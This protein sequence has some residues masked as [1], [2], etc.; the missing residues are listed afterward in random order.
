[1]HSKFTTLLLSLAL[2]LLVGCTPTKQSVRADADHDDILTAD[3]ILR[4]PPQT[5]IDQ[6][7]EGIA[8][9]PEA[10][11]DRAPPK[12]EIELGT[13]KFYKNQPLP[14]ASGGEGQVTFNFENQPIQAVVKAILGDM[15]QENYTIAPNVGGNVTY[16]TSRPIRREDAMP[17]LEMLLSWTGNALVHEGNRY[18]VLPSRD[19]IPGKLTPHAGASDAP[20]YGLRIYPLHYIS[21]VEMAKLLKPYVKPEAIVQIDPNRS[22]LVLAGN[23]S[24]LDIYQRTIDTF[25]VD[26]LKGM[27]IGVYNMQHV[28]VTKL[29]PD[30]DSLFGSKGESPLAGMFRFMPI[31]ETNSII[32]ITPQPEYLKQAEEWLYRLD[33]GSAENAVQ[34]Y[35]YNVK[36]LKAP[37]LADYLSQ[38]FL[39]TASGTHRS[40]TSG[41]VGPGLRSTSLNSMGGMG[42]GM[43]GFNSGMNYGSSLRPQSNI[44]KA[45]PVSSP[46]PAGGAAAAGSGKKETDI[47]ISAIEENNQLMIMAQPFEWE[48]MQA[49]IRRL[50]T[51]PL[52]VQ[53]EARILEVSLTDGLKFGV[54]WWL[55]N[56][57]TAPG[58]YDTTRNPWQYPNRYHRRGSTVGAAGPG[59]NAA[60]FFYSFLNSKFQVAISAL[61]SSGVAKTLSAP[62]LVVNNN[63][64]ASLQI[65]DQIP[66]QQTYYNG[67]GSIGNINNNGNNSGT[68]NPYGSGVMGSVQYLSTG[69][70]LSVLPR[71]NPGGLVYLDIDQQVSTPGAAASAGG[72]PPIAQRQFQ[73]SVAVQSGQTLLLGG[74]IK[75]VRQDADSSVPGIS[76]V[77]ILRRLFGSTSKSTNRTEL[78][79]LITP[80][81]I[82]NSDEARQVTEDYIKQFESLKPLRPRAQSTSA[83]TAEMPPS[84]GSA[85][86]QPQHESTEPVQESKREH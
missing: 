36:N 32:A 5:T 16:S 75:E 66:I 84:S 38:I 59:A 29:M 28:D 58:V 49:A 85:A 76:K 57:M 22:L 79:V 14:K 12:P 34:L 55:G 37:D 44:E 73:T 33:R 40:T 3:S 71:V 9:S 7:V 70:S 65:G 25:D 74:L 31:E 18:T 24:E 80:R 50:D 41:R 82:N 81:V 1:M 13:A 45:A 21:P 46:A 69:V 11:A 26:W 35:V 48:Q 64:E 83:P 62:S 68:Q 77:P 56:L 10:K 51:P 67:L 6:P 39:G 61:E 20:G 8:I 86:M 23:P 78:I 2:A 15:L 53:I 52:Q 63:Q 72:N 4:G 54:Q 19:A 43:G 30:L 17:V 60:S 47:R 27:S 42:G